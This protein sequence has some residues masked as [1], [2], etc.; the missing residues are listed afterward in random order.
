MIFVTVGTLFP[1]DRLIK[2]IDQA[3][4]NGLIKEDVFAQIGESSYKPTNLEYSCV[5]AKDKFDELSR[6]SSGIISHAGMGT[7]LSAVDNGKPLLVMPRLKRFG[8]H[9]NDHQLGT[10]KKFGQLGY[11]LVAYDTD[12]LPGKIR[13]LKD[14]KPALR[15]SQADKVARRIAEFMDGLGS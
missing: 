9:V 4:A 10:A 1:F 14:F 7:I 11:V 13:Q 6:N 5:L 3:C 8:E 15:V 2:A 12:K